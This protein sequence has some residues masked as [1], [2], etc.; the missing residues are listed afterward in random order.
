[1]RINLVDL[2]KS[3]F[4]S[5][6]SAA[7]PVQARIENARMSSTRLKALKPVEFAAEPKI[8]QADIADPNDPKTISK[9]I[10]TLAHLS[11]YRLEAYAATLPVSMENSEEAV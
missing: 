5:P 3:F 10:T 4:H 1:M 6:V 8:V 2:I 9:R 11:H 7:Q